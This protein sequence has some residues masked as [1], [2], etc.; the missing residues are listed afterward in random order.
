VWEKVVNRGRG[1][2]LGSSVMS[3]KRVFDVVLGGAL[4]ASGSNLIS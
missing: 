4:S 2:F 1:S 3:S